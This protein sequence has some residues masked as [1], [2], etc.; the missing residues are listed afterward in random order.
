M[1]NKKILVTGGAGFM[2]SSLVKKLLEKNLEVRVLDNYQRGNG[3][4]LN[5]IRNKID[6]IEGDIRDE[7]IVEKACKGIDTV[8]HLAYL[9]GT[10]FFYTKPDI[11][12]DIAVKGMTNIIDSSIKNNISEFFLA[13]SSEVYQ[14]PDHTPTT[15]DVSLII[16]DILNP[17]YSYGGGKI[18]CELMTVNYGKKFFEKSIIFRPHNVYGPNMGWEHVVPNFITKIFNNS[19]NNDSSEIKL[20]IQGK[21]D[22]TRAFI[23]ID[24]FIDGLLKVYDKGKNLNVYNI[25]TT[26]EISIIDLANK[27]AKYFEKKIKIIPGKIQ[28]G[29][30][31]RRCPDINKISNL[32][33][34]PKYTIEEGIKL[35]ADW[36]IK[37]IK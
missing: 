26:N 28:K 7:K 36:Y 2:G 29:S 5:D 23:Y 3:F 9:N 32:G 4:R 13:S 20:D 35:T 17:R 25:G 15:E 11:V 16:P 34:S 12:L 22:E 37:N 21:G 18:L 27:I 24:D 31:K 6:F 19:L 1:K 14:T 33:F 8:F 10:E 30:T